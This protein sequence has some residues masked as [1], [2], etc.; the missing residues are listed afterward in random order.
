MAAEQRQPLRTEE[1]KAR[2]PST[3]AAGDGG[4]AFRETEL[5][6][7]PAEWEVKTIGDLVGERTLLLQ[8]GFPCGNHNL[9]GRGVPHLR[10]FNINDEGNISLDM[11]KYVETDRDLARYLLADG[12]ILF[13]NTNSEAL[14]GK[15]AYW[16]RSGKYTVSNHM[17]II[18]VLDDGEV[19]AFYLSRYLH[20]RWY[21]GFYRSICRRHVNQASISLA[22]L[23]GVLIPLPPLPEQRRIAHVLR[24]IRRAIEATDRVITAARELKRSL[25]HHLFTYGP[26]P[27]EATG[28]LPLR[29]TDIG[30]VPA[31]WEVVRLGEKF[32]IQQG[33][34]LSRKKDKGVRPRPFLRTANILWG[35]IDLLHLDQMDFSE[36][37]EEK[38][39]LQ[40]GDLLV[41]E[42]GDVG[43]TAIWEGQSEGVYYQNHL[44]RLRPKAPDVETRFFMYWMQAAIKLFNVYL[45]TSNRTTIPNLSRS[46]LS[47]FSIPLPPLSEQREI[48]RILQ[49]V[50]RKIEAEER[51]RAALQALFKT[52]LHLLMTGRIRVEEGQG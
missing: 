22:R 21:D 52:M 49:A 5:G 36:K 27:V 50:D 26:V 45:G 12:D 24:T 2:P 38:Y 7:L 51:R 41:C 11:I 48:A 4:R 1:P 14:V 8:N 30:P 47:S 23:R 25:M 46:R 20:Q 16:D 28:R 37:E 9:E 3:L 13:N 18:R 40:P 44:H 42:G 17:T 32:D 33:K 6:P 31:H 34:A 15:T 43:R 39:R 35:R 19:D 29:E 10:P